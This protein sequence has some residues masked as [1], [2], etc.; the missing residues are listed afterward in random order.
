[1]STGI[2]IVVGVLAIVS[3]CLFVLAGLGVLRFPDLYTRMHAATKATALGALVLGIAAAIA[4]DDADV[5]SVAGATAFAA[6][7]HAGQGCAITTRLV[8]PREKYDEAVQVAAATMESIGAKDPAAVIRSATARRPA[9]P[10]LAPGRKPLAGVISACAA[11]AVRGGPAT[12]RPSRVKT[13]RAAARRG[14]SC[15]VWA[16]SVV[17]GSASATACASS[18]SG[19]GGAATASAIS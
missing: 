18:V 19:G 17:C 3:A 9:A 5:A 12:W 15:G 2:D 8:V 6:C 1:M 13:A 14:S 16:S 7:I 4:L 11:A 10:R